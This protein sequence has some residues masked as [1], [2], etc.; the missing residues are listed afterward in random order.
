VLT[1]TVLKQKFVAVTTFKTK[2]LFKCRQRVSSTFYPS[3]TKM[4]RSII[5]ANLFRNMD[6]CH[7]RS[8]T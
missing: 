3:W 5:V 7:G 6:V 2:R 8:Y 1:Y 4:S